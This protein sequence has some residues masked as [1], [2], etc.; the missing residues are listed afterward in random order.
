[1]P[2]HHPIKSSKPSD[3]IDLSLLSH[4]LNDA[5]LQGTYQLQGNAH[6]RTIGYLNGYCHFLKT[7]GSDIPPELN[8][9]L[10]EI[11]DLADYS[12]YSDERE[13]RFC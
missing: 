3:P 11:K 8:I 5:F 7:S 6:A 1:M 13:R 2:V 10:D 4:I 12:A 9:F